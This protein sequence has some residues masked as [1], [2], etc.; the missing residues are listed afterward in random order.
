MLIEIGGEFACAKRSRC[1]RRLRRKEVKMK[2]IRKNTKRVLTLAL[3]LCL[4][5]VLAGCGNKST[6][7]IAV[8][9]MENYTLTQ[10][11][12]GLSSGATTEDGITVTVEKNGDYEFVL[13]DKDGNEHPF[14]L[15]YENKSAEVVCDEEIGFNL[16]IE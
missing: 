5:F 11:P 13:T 12:S 14:T 7:H 2:Q 1:C 3:V 6:I 8:G 4:M 15:H 9:D 10:I 16:S